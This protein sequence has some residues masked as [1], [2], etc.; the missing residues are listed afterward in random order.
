MPRGQ[1]IQIRSGTAA[2]WSSAN[3]ILA[4]GE[5]G[6]ESDTGK[7]KRGDGATTWTSLA[8]ITD[9]SRLPGS[10]GNVIRLIYAS[11][12]YPIRPTGVAAGLVTYIGPV[13]PTGWL[14]GDDWINNS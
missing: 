10:V 6:L 7:E 13:Q 12:A 14:T 8:Y 2:A 9:V 1:L 4:A 11:G 5:P 3:P